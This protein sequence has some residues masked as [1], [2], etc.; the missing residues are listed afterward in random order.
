[1]NIFRFRKKKDKINNDN[2]LL[3]NYVNNNSQFLPDKKSIHFNS[4]IL[5]II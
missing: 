4:G 3:I 1:M 5:K 2:K